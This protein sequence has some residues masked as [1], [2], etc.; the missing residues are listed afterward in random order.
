[1]RLFQGKQRCTLLSLNVAKNHSVLE[2]AAHSLGFLMLPVLNLETGS[3]YT[4][5]HGQHP[6]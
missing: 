2:R 4:P 5:W 3:V 1:M 6:P